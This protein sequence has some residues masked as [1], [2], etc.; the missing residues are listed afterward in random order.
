MDLGM[1]KRI[2][3]NLRS[4]LSD[5]ITLPK[6]VPEL[7]RLTWRAFTIGCLLCIGFSVLGAI[8]ALLRYEIIG[9]GYLPRGVVFIMLLLLPINALLGRLPPSLQLKRSELLFIFCML[10]AM[11]AIPGQEYANHFYLNLV[12]LVYYSAPGTQWEGMFV[13]HIPEWLLPSTDPRSIAVKGF[14]EGLPEGTS[15]PWLLWLI[16]LAIW[17]VYF[18]L[19]Y[20]LIALFS[21]LLSRQWEERERLLYPLTQVPLEMVGSTTAVRYLFLNP[22]MWVCF[23]FSAGLYLIRGL[24]AYFPS[25]PDLNLQRQ[26]QVLFPAGPLSVFNY[27]PTHIYPEMIGIAYLLSREVAFSFWFFFFL[28]RL[29][30]ALRMWLGINIEHEQFFTMQTI[31]GYIVL[32]ASLLYTA[33]HHITEVFKLALRG[34]DEERES[35]VMGDN[36][37]GSAR[38]LLFGSVA[39]FLG[40]WIWYRIVGIDWFYGLLMVVGLLIASIVVARVVCEAGI[41]VYS[42]PFRVNQAIFDIFGTDRIGAR[43]TVMLTAVSWVQI[44]STATMAMPYLMQCLKIGSAAKLNRRQLLLAMLT[45]I[46]IA[47]LAC[48]ILYP[49]IIYTHGVG[50]LGWWPSRSAFNTSNLLGN[51]LLSPRHMT[52][53]N[54][55]AL[56]W[57]AAFTWFLV[58]MRLTFLSFPFHPLGFVAW[59]GW[60]IDRYWLSILIGWAIKVAVLRFAGY[61]AWYDL[62]P[63]AYGLILG[64]CFIITVWIIVHLFYPAPPVI[65]E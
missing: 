43:N 53:G 50:K 58:K 59:L 2:D 36:P 16:P 32:A 26:T 49:Y 13:K 60:P 48:H 37:A 54:L 25:I 61:K 22:I 46:F 30:Q 29:Q 33:R 38:L 56:L 3:S 39:C 28:R 34:S 1:N 14:F 6:V 42:S 24:H 18:F 23:L 55:A 47:I 8:G 41:F 31:G 57:G 20:A 12:G 65:I 19:V 7:E 9:T 17:S 51:N 15:I 40:I 11:T 27:M 62:R 21:A 44:R 52:A 45:V 4:E 64:I 35:Q 5:V 10:M 63:A